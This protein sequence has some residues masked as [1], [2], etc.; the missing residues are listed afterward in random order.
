MYVIALG[1]SIM[2]HTPF[3]ETYDSAMN[4][5]KDVQKQLTIDRGHIV[6]KLLKYQGQKF[7]GEKYKNSKKD[8]ADQTQKEVEG[9]A[10]QK[11][12]REERLAKI[13]E[14]GSK[15]L[16]SVLNTWK[17]PSPP[18]EPEPW[19]KPSIFKKSTPRKKK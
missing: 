3:P 7:P 9:E 5:T 12:E 8:K 13:Q 15:K 16:H 19:R 11:A 14:D 17:K 18:P 1:R 6:R 10:R 2:K 4:S